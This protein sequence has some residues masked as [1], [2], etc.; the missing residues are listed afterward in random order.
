MAL[1]LATRDG[2]RAIRS[3]LLLLAI[4]AC[5]GAD[6]PA[7]APADASPDTVA[8]TVAD[9]AAGAGPRVLGCS[10]DARPGLEVAAADA[11]TGAALGG[12]TVVLAFDPAG[13][14]PS[15]DSSTAAVQPPLLW[16]GPL[17]RAGRFALR[18]RKVG[19]RPWDTTGVVV[20]RDRCHVQTLRLDIQLVPQ[21]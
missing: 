18:V 9:R 13:S 12:F 10:A 4:T 8:D 5:S 19:Y 17:E 7:R 15:V 6:A 2:H 20:T 16:H 3:L 1:R 21:P 14:A 11:R